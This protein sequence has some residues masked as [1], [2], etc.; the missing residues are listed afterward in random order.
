MS[1]ITKK[2]YKKY[3]AHTD[4][5]FYENNES[6]CPS[7]CPQYREG[8]NA[9]MEFVFNDGDGYKPFKKGEKK[10]ED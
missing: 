5:P 9:A 1:D 8:W 7:K 10:N 3:N 4:C 2:K 6:V